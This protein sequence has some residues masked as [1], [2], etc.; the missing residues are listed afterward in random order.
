MF[1]IPHQ[2]YIIDTEIK[3]PQHIDDSFTLPES[4]GKT[5]KLCRVAFQ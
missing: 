1:K 2:P 5:Y 3:L 4:I